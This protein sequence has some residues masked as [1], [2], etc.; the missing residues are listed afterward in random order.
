[1]LTHFSRKY[2]S[3]AYS[4]A[5]SLVAI[6]ATLVTG[7]HTGD[8]TYWRGLLHGLSQIPTPFRFLLL[9][10][11]EPPGDLTL[12][13][14]RFRWVRL[15]GGSRRWMS[16]V[17]LPL[18]ARRAKAALMHTQYNVSPL[19]PKAVTTIHDVSFF[20]NP[21]W[22]RVKDRIILRTFV[23]ISARRA[24]KVIT[25]SY[26]SKHDILKFLSLSEARVV[27]IYNGVDARFR[28]VPEPERSCILSQ[29]GIT[30]PYVLSVGTR[31]PRKNIGLAIEAM[32]LLPP[33]I[34]HKLVLVGRYGWGALPMHP[35]VH[36]IGYVPDAHLPALYSGASLY[37]CPSHYEG[38]GFP[39]VEAF[40]C[41]APVITS[42][43]GGL[44][45]VAGDAAVVMEDMSVEAWSERITVL[46]EDWSMLTEMRERGFN[47]VKRFSWLD[48]A[49]RT[50]EVYQEVL[51]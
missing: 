27:V 15:K 5:E 47:Q 28:P 18:W 8:T 22:F 21:G 17:T 6:D 2:A 49:R 24:Q 38:F 37:L 19:S 36:E 11:G 34:P 39:V 44:R 25:V 10:V 35:R 9:G 46:L 41:G 42:G 29:Y 50:V 16:L 20:I 4:V 51:G 45:E 23:P 14:E 7:E 30:F 43:G 13:R 48:T 26:A 40:G 1:M 32:S 12:P 33:R 31:W 3:I